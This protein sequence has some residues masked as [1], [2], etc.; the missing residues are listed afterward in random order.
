MTDS[1]LPPTK[2]WTPARQIRFLGALAATRS[3][4]KAAAAAGMSRESAHRLRNRSEGALFASIWDL[5]VAR[6]VMG[7]SEGHSDRLGDGSLLRLLNMHFRR[8][9]GDFAFVR[10]PR[11]DATND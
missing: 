8:K 3:V 11:S 5:A 7:I 4:T 10:Q 9:S 6:P 1:R 2:G